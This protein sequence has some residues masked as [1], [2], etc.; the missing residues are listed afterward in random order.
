LRLIDSYGT[1][2][3]PF[4]IT[5][6]DSVNGDRFTTADTLTSIAI[7]GDTMFIGSDNGIA[8]SN[9]RAQRFKI[10]RVNTDSL[11][12][13]LILQATYENS[14]PLF[15]GITGNFIPAMEVQYPT[16]AGPGIVWASNRPTFGGFD[17]IA[18]GAIVPFV[19]TSTTPDDTIFARQWL[20]QYDQF[21][22]NFA[23]YGDTAFAAT[24][25]G[26]I[27]TLD[28]GF[29][30]DTM[31]YLDTAGNQLYDLSRPVY[32]V[33]AID[34]FLWVGAEDRILRVN[35]YDLTSEGFFVVDSTTPAAEVYAFPVPFSNVQDA[36]T[37]INFR[38]VLEQDASVTI[39]VYD[40]A[41]N[42]VRRVIDNQSFSAGYYPTAIESVKWDALN[43]KGKQLAVG[44][45][46]FK[47]SYSTG[48]E[49]WG[50][51]AIIP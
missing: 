49:R 14:S 39:E 46:Y 31:Q 34:S 4:D 12:A 29:T 41:M 1:G 15:D 13:D 9:N 10:H 28:T 33:A 11:A 48:E 19:D 43:G 38:F 18:V 45:Y 27:Y 32:G 6:V 21:A 35:L 25:N 42:L 2:I 30:W 26:L 22:W 40:F 47:V 36:G 51:L 17:G 24:D 5:V 20:H 3:T 8:I 44:V 23:F 50:K 37:G 16:N 7:H